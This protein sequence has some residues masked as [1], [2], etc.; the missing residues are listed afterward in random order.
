MALNQACE[1][2]VNL[3]MMLIGRFCKFH[4]NKTA[5]LSYASSRQ[6]KPVLSNEIP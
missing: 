6:G 2:M 4:K 1:G 3:Q 5:E